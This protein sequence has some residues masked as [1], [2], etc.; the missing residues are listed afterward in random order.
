[1]YNTP[2]PERDVYPY[3]KKR[4]VLSVRFSLFVFGVF[5]IFTAT[6]LSKTIHVPGDYN[7]IQA[8]IDAS[9]NGDTVLVQPGTYMENIDFKGKAI[10][11]KSSGGP[12]ATVMDG[13]MRGSV[14][15]FYSN[16]GPASVLEG[17]II[18]NGS[19]TEIGV[20][21][22]G[23]GIYCEG[24]SP[25][26]TGNIITNND[27]RWGGGIICDNS[28]PVISENL[29]FENLSIESM[30]GG[31]GIYCFRKSSPLIQNNAILRNEAYEGGG[32]YLGFGNRSIV[33]NNTIIGNVTTQYGGAG[34]H[35][36]AC[37]ATIVNNT[38]YGNRALTVYG[39]G[40]GIYCWYSSLTI[41]NTILW[42]NDAA[43][44][45]EIGMESF[46]GT[47]T[48][49]IL[50]SDVKGRQ[51]SV[52]MDPG[53]TLNWGPGMIDADPLFV[54]GYSHDFHL[55]WNSPCRNAGINAA[56][57]AA[58]DFEGDPRIAH[59]TVDMGA[60]EFHRHLYYMGD[61]TPGYQ[62]SLNFIGAPG[63]AMILF[64]GS[65]LLDPPWSTMYGDWYIQFPL[66]FQGGFGVL[67]ANGVA[68]FSVWISSGIP[69]PWDIPMQAGIGMK[70]TNL[71]VME[72]R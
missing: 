37:R 33:Q 27:A 6:G 39:V 11:V 54:D 55:T 8:A 47:N 17:F 21:T 3:H 63:G 29:I 38:I 22:Y 65:G 23:G 40:G 48:V 44:G 62:V 12:E 35:C 9:R 72:V 43:M 56:V 46:I 25:T 30:G 7:T 66:L 49:T 45:P 58:G 15:S 20:Y 28:S 71:C 67:P 68:A 19:G 64:V 1:V 36:W 4:E 18:T 5:L 57:P 34:I 41:A 2:R 24:A 51:A 60:D 53:V 70:L 50:H 10:A 13:N 61:A 59:G 26:I 69:C 16:E 31:G 42:N 52:H 32:I 14:V